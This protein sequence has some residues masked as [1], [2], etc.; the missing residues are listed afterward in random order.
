MNELE[1]AINKLIGSTTQIIVNPDTY[2]TMVAQGLPISQVEPAPVEEYVPKLFETKKERALEIIKY[3]PPR[4]NFS[5]T[6]CNALY[7]EIYEC[8]IFGLNGA[9]ITLCGILVEFALK[10]ALYFI[11]NGRSF[12]YRPAL[13]DKFEN[14]TLDP[15][16]RRA[17][18]SGLIDESMATKLISFK[19]DIRNPYNHYNIKKITRD[20]VASNVRILNIVTHEVETVTL[21][22]KDSPMIHA[23]AK[24]VFDTEMVLPVL[25]FADTVIRHLFHKLGM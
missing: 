8:I 17:K 19:E 20:V 18:V 5:L 3:L 1:K 11:E 23:Q 13:W 4:N 2:K 16:I 24:R 7:D 12:E 25:L 21:E 9:A 6:S 15:V 10:Q 22:A 14:M